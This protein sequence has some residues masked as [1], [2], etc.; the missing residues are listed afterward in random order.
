MQLN[1]FDLEETKCEGCQGNSFFVVRNPRILPA[2]ISATG[3]EANCN[4]DGLK[5]TDCGKEYYPWVEY[6]K[7]QEKNNQ[8]IL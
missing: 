8:I 4:I 6:E 5:C 1:P 7:T 2:T 3:Q